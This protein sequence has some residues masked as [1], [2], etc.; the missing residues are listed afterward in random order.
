[1]GGSYAYGLSSKGYNVY[2]IDKDIDAINYAKDKG[3]IINGSV[4]ACDFISKC[5]LIIICLYPDAVIKFLSENK[6][7][8][9]S[10]QIITDLCGVK[11]SF[12]YKID[13]L[14]LCCEYLTHHPMAGKET[15]GIKYA[16]TEMFK[17]ANF[18]I[19]HTKNTTNKAISILNQV[20]IDLEFNKVTVM[21]CHKH[22]EMIAYTSQLTHAIAVSLVNSDI[23]PVET[24]NYI[25]DSYRD[26][27]RIAAIN[28]VLWSE[29]FFEN[30]DNLI[31][32]IDLFLD[33][34]INI[35][36]C[37]V[38]DDKEELKKIF[39]KSSK[40]RKEMD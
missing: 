16:N 40:R 23:D 9:N 31:N 32:K 1:M 20:A 39:I 4:N 37:L 33:S 14:N 5:E 8:F 11:E 18:L 15:S 25:G 26:L 12:I 6:E 27:T 3:Y 35:K 19:C 2:G 17:K 21:S 36:Q 10:N 24:N 38:N 13:E 29:L 7:Y 22:D 34:I 30:K 28:E